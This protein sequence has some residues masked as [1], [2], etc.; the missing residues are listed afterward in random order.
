ME[1]LIKLLKE[2]GIKFKAVYSEDIDIEDH[3]IELGVGKDG[4]E[5]H[6][7]VSALDNHLSLCSWDGE[8]ICYIVDSDYAPTIV[9]EIHN[10]FQGNIA[11]TK[12]LTKDVA[13]HIC[14]KIMG[15]KYSHHDNNTQYD[16]DDAPHIYFYQ[17]MSPSILSLNTTTGEIRKDRILQML[18]EV[19]EDF[20]EEYINH[21]KYKNMF[22]EHEEFLVKAEKTKEYLKE[23]NWL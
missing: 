1:E 10:H 19:I 16:W 9:N 7:Q 18:F 4:D 21:P 23:N 2:N 11:K 3:M 14:E 8:Q 5:Y 15:L 17:G 20:K 13:R 6:I 22:K 12:S